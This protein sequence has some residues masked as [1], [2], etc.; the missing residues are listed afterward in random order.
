MAI[1][2]LE[3][4]DGP[5]AAARMETR[6]R[7]IQSEHVHRMGGPDYVTCA[8]THRAENRKYAGEVLPSIPGN[9]DC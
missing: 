2:P 7:L 9:Q 6:P 8:R 3:R 1:L 4:K 5:V